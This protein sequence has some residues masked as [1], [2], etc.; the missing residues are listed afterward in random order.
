M[1][2]TLSWNI[3]GVNSMAAKT[4]QDYKKEIL[5]A[6]KD[7]GAQGIKKTALKIKTKAA[8][9][10]FKQLVKSRTIANIG[11]RKK[12]K[13]VMAQH[14]R[15]LEMAYQ[16]LEDKALSHKDVLISKS[17]LFEGLTGAAGKKGDEALK[18]LR[19]EGRLMV[20]K[21]SGR[22]FFAHADRIRKNLPEMV[23]NH[24]DIAGRVKAA[25]P[26][27]KS[28]FGFSDV[29][30]SDLQKEA[31]VPMDELKEFLLKESRPGGVAQLGKGDWSLSSEEVRSGAVTIDG[32]PFL[33]V[34]I[35]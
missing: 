17:K 8:V 28:N 27:V 16:R 13:W 4:V 6:V 19:Q 24:D 34:R 3:K 1:D 25:Y 32:T 5:A 31:D 33:M 18:F 10:A 11:S 23:M 26:R 35:K 7:T 15:P 22:T 20:L 2:M 29:R 21:G 30:I 9:E 12:Q 14:Y